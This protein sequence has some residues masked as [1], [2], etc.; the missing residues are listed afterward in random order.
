MN[1][2]PRHPITWAAGVTV[3]LW[4]VLASLAFY[5]H[6]SGY[7]ATVVGSL[8]VCFLIAGW[9]AGLSTYRQWLRAAVVV[10]SVA[11]VVLLFVVR[12]GG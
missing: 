12:R 6:I 2:Q 4:F 7:P 3:L 5:A 11:F 1:E 10:A 8:A 9:G